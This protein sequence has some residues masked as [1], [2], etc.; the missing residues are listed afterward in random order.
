M[1]WGGT[2][3]PDAGECTSLDVPSP[4]AEIERRFEV[5]QRASHRWQFVQFRRRRDDTI[6][7]HA[8]IKALPRRVVRQWGRVLL[9]L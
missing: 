1:E 5:L 9:P 4:G 3:A 6:R 7:Y 8:M 2:E